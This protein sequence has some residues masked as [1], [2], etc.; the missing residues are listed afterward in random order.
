[1][2]NPSP[3]ILRGFP[4][5]VTHLKDLTYS[6]PTGTPLLADLYLPHQQTYPAP[7][8]LW[9]HP[10]GW[11]AG[12]RHRA[13]HLS[14]FFAE[15][16]FAMATI[17]YRLSREALFPAALHDVIAAIAWVRAASKTYHLDPQR[18]GLWGASAG[19]HLAALAALSAPETNIK[20]VAA[21]YPPTDF[22]QM[23]RSPQNYES[24]FLGAPVET[25]PHLVHQANPATWAHPGAPP[26]LILDGL[27]DTEVPP[28]QSELLYEALR[29][30]NNEVTLSLIEGLPHS[31]LDD[32]DFDQGPPRRHTLRISKPGEPESK[33]EAPPLTFGTIETFFRRHL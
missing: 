14:R 7:V 11:I 21:A 27:A 18:I 3:I 22:L 26:F 12:D 23:P 19:G 28:N 30:H 6:T 2:P 10:G 5:R 8:I 9:L 13:P 16:G 33:T 15:R 24:R 29:A 25:V 31:F 4:A 17:D 1:M 32:N 20:A